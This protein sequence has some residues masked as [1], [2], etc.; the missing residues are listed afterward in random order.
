MFGIPGQTMEDFS[1]DLEESLVNDPNH[2]SLY[3]L[4]IHPGTP[5]FTTSNPGDAIGT[6]RIRT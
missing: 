3:G 2:L 5:F 6:E 1:Q 4:E